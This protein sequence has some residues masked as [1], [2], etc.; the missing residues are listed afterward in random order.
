VQQIPAG[1]RLLILAT[2]GVWLR[3]HDRASCWVERPVYNHASG[4]IASRQAVEANSGRHHARHVHV[5]STMKS[6]HSGRGWSG[7]R[8]ASFEGGCSCGGRHVCVGPRGGRYCI[9]SGGNKR[10]GL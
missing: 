2:H 6:V 1:R 4:R 7:S 9:T 5:A 10:Y 3:V 8:A